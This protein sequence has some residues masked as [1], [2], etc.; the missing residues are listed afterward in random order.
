VLEFSVK[1]TGVGIPADQ[2]DKLFTPFSQADSS[3]TRKYGGTGLGL[4]IVKS[5]AI[6]MNGSVGVESQE[7]QGSKFWIRV[8]VKR[9]H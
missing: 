9:L 6:A 7:M 2:I 1:D 5:F 3:I 8:P 4:S